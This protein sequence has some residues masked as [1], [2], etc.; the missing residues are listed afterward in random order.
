MKI[1]KK[2]KPNQNGPQSHTV[3]FREC[4]IQQHFPTKKP[5]T[6]FW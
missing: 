4:E 3:N 2:T 1:N 5:K 6:T